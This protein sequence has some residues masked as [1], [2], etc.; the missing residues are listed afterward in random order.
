METASRIGSGMA[1]GSGGFSMNSNLSAL[2]PIPSERGKMFSKLPV[3]LQAH[4]ILGER[5]SAG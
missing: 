4:G 1:F 3:S 2:P 5:V